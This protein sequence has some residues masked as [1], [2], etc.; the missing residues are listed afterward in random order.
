M[1][2]S[3]EHDSGDL[4][5][6]YVVPDGFEGVP[7]IRVCNGGEE[8]VVLTANEAREALVAA[9]RHETGQCGFSIDS[10]LVPDLPELSELELYDAETGLLIYRRPSPHMMANKILRLETHLFPL[11]RLDDALRPNFQYHARGIESLGRE[12]VTQLFLLGN[13]DS[14]YISGRILY[15]N[16]AYFVE[17]AFQTAILLQNP[18]EEMAE[19]LLVLS[20][21]RRAGANILGVRETMEVASA[22]DFAEGLPFKDEKALRRALRQIPNDVGIVFANPLTRQLTAATPDEMPTGGAVSTALHELS[23]FAVVGLRHESDR[24]LS[25]LAELI[26][27][28][29]DALPPVQQ[30]PDVPRVAEILKSSGQVD[31]LLEKDLELYHH[32]AEAAEKAKQS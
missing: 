16:Y 32:I 7:R 12:T 27:V 6:V 19:R 31:H 24:F 25:A 4:V 26:G 9:S 11:W 3:L 14:V 23:N 1:L 20:K 15:K 30:F 2:F 5:V 17:S 10:S 29:P 21:I 8:L 13:V 28:E 18:Y 22:L